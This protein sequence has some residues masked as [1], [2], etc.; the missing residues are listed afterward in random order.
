MILTE[1]EVVDAELALGAGGVVQGDDARCEIAAGDPD[2]LGAGDAAAVSGAEL[3]AGRAVGY[4]AEEG[5]FGEWG[6]E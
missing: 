1:D 3:G 2:G 5:A 6:G 4:G